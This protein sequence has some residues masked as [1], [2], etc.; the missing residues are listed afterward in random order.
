[1]CSQQTSTTR[2]V[3]DKRPINQDRGLP[4]L[5]NPTAL[6]NR[7][8]PAFFPKKDADVG[9]AVFECTIP[10]QPNALCDNDLHETAL[11]TKIKVNARELQIRLWETQA[12]IRPDIEF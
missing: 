12:T 11:A 6:D 9:E 10:A 1:V 2:L 3:S 8:S 4:S 7:S 5:T